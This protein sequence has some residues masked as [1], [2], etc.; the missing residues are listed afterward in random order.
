MLTVALLA[1]SI[2]QGPII[3]IP[4]PTPTAVPKV[5]EVAAVEKAKPQEFTARVGELKRLKGEDGTKWELAAGTVGADLVADGK[6]GC[7]FSAEAKGRYTLVCYTAG[8]CAWVVVTVGDAL[9]VPVPPG[10]APVPPA[11]VPPAPIPP[12]PKPPLSLPAERLLKAIEKDGG[13]TDAN[14]KALV[15]LEALAGEA[16]DFA[17]TTDVKFAFALA[18][19]IQEAAKTLAKDAAPNVRAWFNAELKSIVGESDYFL[20][21]DKRKLIGESLAKLE[22][23]FKEVGK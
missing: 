4:V 5:S 7:V 14:K 20:T 23:V 13:F 1:L 6:G 9:P 21:D 17:K 11:P 15:A 12:Q 8:P 3:P 2:A 16:V 22:A 10:P 18:T 19:K